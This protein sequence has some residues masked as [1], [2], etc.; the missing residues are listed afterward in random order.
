MQLEVD[1]RKHYVQGTRRFEL[2]VAFRCDA[3]RLVLLGPSGSGKSLTLKA[4]AGLM[5]PD[6][7]LIRLGGRTL[8]D[9]ARGVALPA[10]ERKMGYLFQDYALMP[11]LTVRQN[12]AFG[13]AGSR[14][15]NPARGVRAPEAERWIDA[16]G[17][18]ALADAYPHT[19]SGQRQRAA[20]A[21]ALAARPDA[22]LLDEPFAALDA[23]LRARMR[24]EL[25]GLLAHTGI[26]LVLISHDPDD[27]AAF[28]DAVFT[29]A[30]GRLATRGA[31]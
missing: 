21:R 6:A 28:G 25:S 15:F 11:H 9:A 30:D 14:W 29:L 22:L 26:P 16:F 20:L 17:L 3:Q 5:T 1:I 4:I 7:G 27:A 19:L 10:R 31:T 2:D 13:V 18:A 8:F 23:P 24:A 12:V